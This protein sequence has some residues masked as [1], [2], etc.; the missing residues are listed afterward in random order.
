M[1]YRFVGAASVVENLAQIGIDDERKRVEF[2]GAPVII[3]VDAWDVD[4][5]SPPEVNKSDLEAL[6]RRGEQI[7]DRAV[8][9]VIAFAAEFQKVDVARALAQ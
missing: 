3:P 6:R 7:I 4:I 2:G 5:A 9:Y 1:S 8:E